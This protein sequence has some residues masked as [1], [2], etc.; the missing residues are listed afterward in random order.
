MI[1]KRISVILIPCNIPAGGILPKTSRS[2]SASF[3]FGEGFGL[4]LIF[5][6]VF[7]LAVIT[8]SR[9]W[10]VSSLASSFSTYPK[11]IS[12]HWS[13][14]RNQIKTRQMACFDRV[15]LLG[16]PRG[17]CCAISFCGCGGGIRTHDLRVL[18]NCN[19]LQDRTIPSSTKN[20][21]APIIVSERF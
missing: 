7:S 8:L 16:L 17:N 19:Y 9:P 21:D 20:V 18:C 13:G 6:T 4:C 11:E 15:R 1:F 2:P 5:W 12:K 3:L 14:Y 10:P